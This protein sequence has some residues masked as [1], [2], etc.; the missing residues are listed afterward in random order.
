MYSPGTRSMTVVRKA[1]TQQ[2]YGGYFLA[3]FLVLLFCLDCRIW[4]RAKINYVF[5]FEFEPRHNLD[6]RQLSE[7]VVCSPS[8]NSPLMTNYRYPVFCGFFLVLR[9]GLTFNS[10]HHI[11]CFC[12]GPYF[13]QPSVHSS[14]SFRRRCCTIKAGS[15]GPI[16]M[17]QGPLPIAARLWLIVSQF[18]L[19]LAGIYPVEF[20]DFFLGDMYCSQTYAMGVND[21]PQTVG[22]RMTNVW[23]EPRTLLLSICTPLE[24]TLAMQFFA[25]SADWILLYTSWYLERLAVFASL[26]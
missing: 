24:R 13:L 25:L 26:L 6:W 21:V 17:Y 18:R 8:M 22:K 1:D 12:T 20:R 2:I 7:V 15:G 23:S 9:F 5:I 11:P 4:A 19:L 14:S 16:L 3:L 10:R